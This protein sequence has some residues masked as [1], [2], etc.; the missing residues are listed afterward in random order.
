MALKRLCISVAVILCCSLV[1]GA[2]RDGTLCEALSLVGAGGSVPVLL[3]GVYDVGVEHSVLYDPEARSC[4]EDVQPETWLAVGPEVKVPDSLKMLL[5]AHGRALVSVRGRLLGPKPARA[6]LSADPAWLTI[7]QRVTGLRYG[8]NNYWRTARCQ[9]VS[10]RGAG[11]REHPAL[12]DEPC[13]ASGSS[14]ANRCRRCI[15]G[16]SKCRTCGRHIRNGSSQSRGSQRRHLVTKADLRRR[17]LAEE[18]SRNIR[19]WRFSARDSVTFEA[20]YK[21]VLEN[22]PAGSDLNTHVDARLP[23]LVVVVAP[24]DRW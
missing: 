4:P 3:T 15:A 10:F 18:A 16:I 14:S 9:R 7:P 12:R 6:D 21:Y 19:T 22:R 5:A 11:R 23:L 24:T 13:Q 2:V 1:D 8:H 20:S 17:L